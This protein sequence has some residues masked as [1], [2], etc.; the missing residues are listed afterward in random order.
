MNTPMLHMSTGSSSVGTPYPIT[1][2]LTIRRRL[3]KRLQDA[4]HFDR[5]LELPTMHGSS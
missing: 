5:M 2:F 1:L 4:S 3:F